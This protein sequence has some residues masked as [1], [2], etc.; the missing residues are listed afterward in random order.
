MQGL[1]P[2]QRS[3]EESA[4]AENAV[5]H[6]HQRPKGTL[7]AYAAFS[8]ELN[9]DPVIVSALESGWRVALPLIT[10]MSRGEMEL[11][12]IDSLAHLVSG[13]MNIRQ[14]SPTNHPKIHPTE[15]DLALI[16]AWAFD[17]NTGARLGKGGG[18]YDR[19]LANPEWRAETCGI[20]FHC[21]LLD[22]LPVEPHDMQVD[23]IFSPAG[24]LHIR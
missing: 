9:I 7:F 14:P 10:N 22:E 24:L 4:V 15:I 2:T 16:P 12:Q 8:P 18:F 5:N 11:R 21:Q 3:E 19:L 17:R 1:S 6:L 13:P 23:N 20:A